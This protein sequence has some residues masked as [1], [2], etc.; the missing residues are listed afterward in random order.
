M[1]A[2]KRT[3]LDAVFATEE[4]PAPKP[5]RKN[6]ATVKP[7][8]AAKPSVVEAQPQAEGRWLKAS[9]GKAAYSVFATGRSRAASQARI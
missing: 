7:E 9:C 5:P 6:N 2:K 3:S 4:L 1:N 8:E